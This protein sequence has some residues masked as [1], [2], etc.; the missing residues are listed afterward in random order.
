MRALALVV[1]GLALGACTKARSSSSHTT[2]TECVAYR[3]KLFSLLPQDEQDAMRKGG[4]DKAT[5]KE[6]EMCRQRVHSDEIACM[7]KATTLDDALACKPAVDDRPDAVKRTPEECQAYKE[8]LLKLADVA[9]S[10][11]AFGPAL[12][13]SMAKMAGRECER[14]MTKKRYDCIMSAQT[15]AGMIQCPA[16]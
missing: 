12:T 13:R 11:D 16:D 5:P 1:A 6:I 15:S 2:E 7:Q 10:D 9:A 8:H 14:W 4:N 3:D